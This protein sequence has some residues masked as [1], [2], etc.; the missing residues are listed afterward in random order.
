MEKLIIGSA[1]FLAIVTLGLILYLSTGVKR[2]I[3]KQ[4]LMIL[5]KITGFFVSAIAAQIIFT[6]IQNCQEMFKLSTIHF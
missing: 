4:D 6:G 5:P 2:L 1:L 3:G